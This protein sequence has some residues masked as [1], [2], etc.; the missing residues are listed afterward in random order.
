MPTSPNGSAPRLN[1]QVVSTVDAGAKTA[2]FLTTAVTNNEYSSGT[3]TL[4]FGAVS[5][6]LPTLT[7]QL[8]YSPDAGT[9]WLSLGA[10]STAITAT[11]NSVQ[12]TVGIGLLAL[13]S[14]ATSIISI[15]TRLP[16]MWRLNCVIGG[17]TPSFALTSVC[18]DYLV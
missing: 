9:T 8:Q 4:L 18:V 17:T 2:T 16:I 12:F 14:G 5:G 6:T 7:A 3:I 15:G 11:G 13:V 1:R 10:A